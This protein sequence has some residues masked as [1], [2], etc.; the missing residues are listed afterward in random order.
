MSGV[1]IESIRVEIMIWLSFVDLMSET[2]S[3]HLRRLLFQAL[4]Q[5]VRR[6]REELLEAED[7]LAREERE[8]ASSERQLGESKL[9]MEANLT[10]YDALFRQT[11]KLTEE[12][13]S[14]KHSNVTLLAENNVRR[15]NITAR[16]IE[17]SVELKVC[18]THPRARAH[19]HV[20]LQTRIC[21]L[22]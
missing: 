5:D 17:I 22:T 10:N 15:D 12:L 16:E 11:Q 3:P 20:H 21:V 19:L 13:E 14:Q 6:K 18:I 1:A 8:I 7:K 9:K 4:Q 2:T